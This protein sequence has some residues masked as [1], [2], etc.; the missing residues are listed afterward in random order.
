MRLVSVVTPCYNE[1]GNVKELY[2]RVRAV[3]AGFPA[4]RYEHIFIDNDSRDST[5]AIL[6]QIASVD[7]NVKIIVNCR[8]FGHLRSPMHAIYQAS[9]DVIIL[10]FADLQDP[11]ELLKDMLLEWEQGTPVVLAI[12][13]TSDESGLM[14]AIRTAYYRLVSRLADIPLY[15][16]FTGFGLYDRQTD[17]H[18]QKPVPRSLPLF[19]R[20]DRRGWLPAQEGVLQPE[21]PFSRHH[22]EQ[23]LHP[24][25][26]GDAQHYEP[27][28]G[29]LARVHVQ[30]IRA[31]TGQFAHG[32]LLLC[33]QT[34][35]LEQFHRGHRPCCDRRLLS[36][37]YTIDWPWHP[38]GIHRIHPHHGSKSSARGRKRANQF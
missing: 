24:V 26:S 35:V 31:F 30:W 6:K 11:P 38:G 2:E 17:R 34:G 23:L 36:D 3:L 12:K 8:N 28:E 15:E 33:V 20:H 10:L 5:V 29:A 14:F 21:A 4:Y 25:R 1:E 27:V 18:S 16:H 22:Q 9:G 32:T 19:S 13:N 37:F 7:R